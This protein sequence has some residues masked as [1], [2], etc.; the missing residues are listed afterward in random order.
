MGLHL[1][2]GSTS[3]LPSV[4]LHVRPKIKGL[5]FTGTDRLVLFGTASINALRLS[6]GL[7]DVF[8]CESISGTAWRI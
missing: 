8:C 2:D 4:F 1:S 7:F 6:I 3:S 5:G